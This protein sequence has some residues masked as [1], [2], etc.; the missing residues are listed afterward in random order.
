MGGWEVGKFYENSLTCPNASLILIP[1]I[2]FL[3][4]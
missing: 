2:P 1:H 3:I 4:R